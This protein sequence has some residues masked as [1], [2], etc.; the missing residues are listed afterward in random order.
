MATSPDS[1]SLLSIERVAPAVH[2]RD[3]GLTDY[4]AALALQR[5][6]R[7]ARRDGDGVDTLLLTEHRP[8]FTLGNA[9]GR[10]HVRVSDE[11]LAARGVPLVPVERG[12]DVTYHGPGQLVIYPILDLNGF[13]RDVRLYVRRL[14]ETAIRLLAHYE[15]AGERRAGTPGVWVGERKIAS[16]GVHL[17]RWITLH[18]LAINLDLDL[19]PFGWIDPCGLV[20]QAMTSVALERP[21]LP[22]D[23]A[24]AKRWY[25]AGFADVFGCRLV[26]AD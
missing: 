4:A 16:V 20:G 26:A 7:A 21:D 22:I 12:G 2:L 19:E 11:F 15:V 14:E 18:G 1:P 5:E 24:E 25:A 13:A 23:L 10:E 6:L 17:S 8:V 3:L 9:A